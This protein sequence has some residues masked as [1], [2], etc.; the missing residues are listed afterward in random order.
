MYNTR[1]HG[2]A[3]ERFNERRLREDNAK[4]LAAEIPDL[5]TLRMDIEERTGSAGIVEPPHIR[6]IVVASAPAL[7]VLPCGDTRCRDG[8][9]DVTD[10]MMRA[11]H[12]KNVS[13]EGSDSCNGNIGSAP[14]NR[15]LQFKATATYR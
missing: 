6:R 14:C 8:G 9:H 1:R 15:V 4:R 2:E 11:L 13:F 12:A 10:M 3:A 5:L 7:F